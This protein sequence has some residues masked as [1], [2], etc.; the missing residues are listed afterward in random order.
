MN[1]SG[2][3]LGTGHRDV[4]KAVCA[5]KYTLTSAAAVLAHFD[6]EFPMELSVDAIPFIPME[7]VAPL[8]NCHKL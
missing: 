3:H 4:K 8:P 7:T 5:V 2:P 6:A 1:S